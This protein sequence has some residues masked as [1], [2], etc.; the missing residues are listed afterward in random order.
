MTIRVSV[1]GVITDAEEARIPVLD[2]GFLYGDAVF[3]VF[4]TYG[5]VP[6]ELDVHL[7]RLEGS[8][9][10]LRFRL[11]V[12]RAQLA[13]EVAAA[14]ADAGHPESYVR[15]VVTR[16][17]GPL[18]LDPT[19][20]IHPLRVIVVA[21]LVT[22]PPAFYEAGVAVITLRSSH[23]AGRKSTAGAKVANYVENILATVEAKEKGAHEAF[24]VDGSGQVLEGATSNVFVVSGGRVRTPPLSTGILG[25]ITRSL[26]L[27][28]ARELGI[29]ADEEPLTAHDLRSAEE[30]FLTSSIREVVPVIRL[31]GMDVGNGR[32]GPVARRLLVAYRDRL[33]RTYGATRSDDG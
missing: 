8:A 7:A 15:V 16:G 30:I 31:D 23:E 6:H 26:V 12:S 4:R 20:A 14:I 28:V 24:F 21:P 2:R 27:D 32:P 25:G 10:R 17:R 11:P 9:E 33:A 5:G 13:E 29:P 18:G 3:E 19:T 22:P 1:D